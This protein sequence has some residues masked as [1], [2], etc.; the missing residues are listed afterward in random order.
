MFVK[1]MDWAVKVQL[2]ATQVYSNIQLTYFR[3]REI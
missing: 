1:I 3:I 2:N